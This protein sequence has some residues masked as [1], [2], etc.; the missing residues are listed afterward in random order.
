MNYAERA[1]EIKA[2][3]L[4]EQQAILE[5]HLLADKEYKDKINAENE[6]TKK[7][8]IPYFQDFAGYVINETQQLEVKAIKYTH[9]DFMNREMEREYVCLTNSHLFD[10]LDEM[11]ETVIC[12]RL[13]ETPYG[14]GYELFRYNTVTLEWYG[15][16]KDKEDLMEGV[17]E[18][19][20][21]L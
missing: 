20:S 14:Y 6:K 3:T 12:G 10:G 2:K 19:V 16:Y 1:R 8:L 13:S 7:E 5:K 17:A 9:K 11:S 15:T 18:L 21:K 4:L